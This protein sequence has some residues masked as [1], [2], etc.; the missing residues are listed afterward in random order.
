M[1]MCDEGF[2]VCVSCVLDR[3]QWS[4]CV[5]VMLAC[6]LVCGDSCMLMVM[7]FV[8]GWQVVCVCAWLCACVCSVGVHFPCYSQTIC[9]AGCW[10]Q[11][12]A[13]GTAGA[14]PWLINVAA[15]TSSFPE[16][17]QRPHNAQPVCYAC[18]SLSVDCG[19][20]PVL[21]WGSR[22]AKREVGTHTN[23]HFMTKWFFCRCYLID[24]PFRGRSLRSCLGRMRF[25]GDKKGVSF[26]CSC[27]PWWKCAL[28]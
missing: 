9:K 15:R 10:S 6:A 11:A 23:Y 26:S 28:M 25:E 8:C 13:C 20:A 18:L 17:R 24:L 12:E 16:W 4:H 3:R 1:C 14:P 2:C 22:G 21:S 19:P 27:P 5:H 7:L